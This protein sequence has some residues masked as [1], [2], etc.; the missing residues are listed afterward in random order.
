MIE[1]INPER[2]DLAHNRSPSLNIQSHF[3]IYCYKARKL[4]K[5][6]VLKAKNLSSL[7]NN[8]IPSVLLY[9]EDNTSARLQIQAVSTVQQRAEP[10]QQAAFSQPPETKGSPF[11]SW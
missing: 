5:A 1:T 11:G 9:A 4:V 8:G 7:Q 2:I 10:T 3:T 6:I